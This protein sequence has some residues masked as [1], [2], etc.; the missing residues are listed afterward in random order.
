MNFISFLFGS[1]LCFIPNLMKGVHTSFDTLDNVSIIST[2]VDSIIEEEAFIVNCLYERSIQ[3]RTKLIDLVKN[4]QENKS[5]PIGASNLNYLKSNTNVFMGLRDSLFYFTYKHEKAIKISNHKLKNQ[6]VTELQ[7]TK[8][9]MISTASALLL[10][11]NYLIGVTLLEQDARLRRIANDPDI[12][13]NV[14]ENQLFE[15]SKSAK[16]L[17]NQKRILKG[18]DFIEAN[19]HLFYDTKDEEY[20]FLKDIIFS[21]PSYD[22]LKKINNS[23]LIVKKIGLA[24]V[25]ISD[26]VIDFSQNSFNTLSK[27]FGNLTGAVSVRKGKMYSNE[28]LKQEILK[29]LQPLDILLEKTPFRLTDKLIP[30]YFGH[31]SIWVG[32]GLELDS[33]GIWEHDVVI[34]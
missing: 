22:Y 16:S 24:Q 28:V 2:N 4:I 11:D 8:A 25:F 33:M 10:Y 34:P 31:V 7:R 26:L 17:K 32:N 18:I 5:E 14:N 21:S 23:K 12:G 27:F 3:V 13:F 1:L 29:D 9:V 19:E 15:V 30:G 6:G 20:L